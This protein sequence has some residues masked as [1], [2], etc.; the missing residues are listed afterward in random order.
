MRCSNLFRIHPQNYFYLGPHRHQCT[1]PN[2]EVHPPLQN[3]PQIIIITTTKAIII[4]I[5][6]SCFIIE[7]FDYFGY[8]I[9]FI[10]KILDYL[11]FDYFILNFIYY[12]KEIFHL[13]YFNFIIN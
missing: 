5:F 12:L 11:K 4:I 9:Y 3:F 13:N 10:F 7:L 8:F 6:E 1:P 2:Y